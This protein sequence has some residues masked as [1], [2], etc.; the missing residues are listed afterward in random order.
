M[1]PPDRLP[2]DSSD[3]ELGVSAEPPAADWLDEIVRRLE[4]HPDECWPALESLSALDDEIRTEVVEALAHHCEKPGV[5]ELL[6]LIGGTSPRDRVGRPTTIATRTTPATGALVLGTRRIARSLVTPI[7]GEGRATIVI[8]TSDRGER[9]TAAFHC[10]VRHGIIDAVGTVEEDDLAA[11]RMID[12]AIA[13]ADAHHAADAHE[14]AVRLLEGCFRLTGPR[15]ADHVRDWFDA[16]IG[17]AS[18][19]TLPAPTLPGP[20]LDTIPDPEL[21]RATDRILDA[22]PTWID[23][24]PLTLELAEEIALREGPG[25]PDPARDAGAYRYLF[26]HLLLGRLELYAR[27][28]LWMAWVWQAADHRDLSTAAF[29]LAAQLSDE[30]YAVPS[31]PFTVAFTTRSLRSAQAMLV[32]I[33]RPSSD[34]SRPEP[35]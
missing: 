7:D 20:D 32:E 22:C 24:S 12:E 3:P 28:L 31:H 13:D 14:L 27:M 16:T 8:S 25:S 10:D 26:E 18:H 2:R 29:A 21:S 15:L 34:P 4:E 5:R 35:L 6:S 23:R 30:Q 19:A 9:R 1:D 11:G 17:P 33:A